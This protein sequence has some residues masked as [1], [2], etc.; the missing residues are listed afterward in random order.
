M[1]AC[2]LTRTKLP[3]KKKKVV[4][5]ITNLHHILCSAVIWLIIF[6]LNTLIGFLIGKNINQINNSYIVTFKALIKCLD[7]FIDF[8]N[9]DFS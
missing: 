3:Q 8:A 9:N 6:F 5:P 2:Q 4:Y 7:N 1:K